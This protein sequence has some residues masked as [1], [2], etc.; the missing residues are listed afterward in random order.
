MRDGEMNDELIERVAGTLREPVR[1]SPAV[2]ARVMA[3]VRAIAAGHAPS[4]ARAPEGDLLVGAPTPPRELSL[5]RQDGRRGALGWLVRPRS[6]NVSPLGGLALAAGLAA[7]VVLADQRGRQV[8]ASQLRDQLAAAAAAPGASEGAQAYK[9]YG[10][11]ESAPAG[12]MRVVS[13]TFAAPGASRVSLAAD[14]N[15]WAPDALPL[16]QAAP[17]VWS[18]SVPLA[19]GR[20]SY[21]FVVDGETWEADP[22]APRAADDFGVPSSTLVVGAR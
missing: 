19:A 1:V 22:A 4:A 2:D 8:G 7:I 6:L 5:V 21:S 13:F 20:Y 3:A 15:D 14:F 17:G 9:V 16:T 12:A 11:S 10:P 18:V